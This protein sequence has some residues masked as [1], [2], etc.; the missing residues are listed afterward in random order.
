M[1]F[2]G[3]T[4][5]G[6]DIWFWEDE[7]RRFIHL[8]LQDTV[9]APV[10]TTGPLPEV[11]TPTCFSVHPQGVML[12]AGLDDGSFAAWTPGESDDPVI[13]EQDKHDGACLDVA[14]LPL[15]SAQRQGMVSAEIRQAHEFERLSDA[16]FFLLGSHV[17][18]PQAKAQFLV[19]SL[20]K[21]L[22]IRILECIPN[23]PGKI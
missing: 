1:S 18:A 3:F 5:V 8:A 4:L 15:A 11:Y 17:A 7:Q 12:L 16:M 13:H 2:F 23:S 22:M 10:D 19:H 21:E 9:W 6:P 14:F 20:R